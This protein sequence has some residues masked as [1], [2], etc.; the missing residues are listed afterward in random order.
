MGHDVTTG[1]NTC[2]KSLEAAAEQGAKLQK[3][4]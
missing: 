4:V 2:M 3:D 1:F